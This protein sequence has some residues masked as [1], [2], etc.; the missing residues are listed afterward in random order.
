MKIIEGLENLGIFEDGTIFSFTSCKPLK[1]SIHSS[2]YEY[3]QFV[4]NGK[5]CHALVHRL[6]AKAF[7]PN[8]DNKPCINHIDGNKTNN[9]LENLEWCTYSENTEH[10]AKTLK[11]LTQYQKYNKKRE[12]PVQGIYPDGHK[13]KIFSSIKEASDAIGATKSQLICTLK[14]RKKTCRGA[15]WI[16]KD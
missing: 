16:Y 12:R 15:V 2:G 9:S 6:L 14:G 11:R 10:A 3:V 4:H 5:H 1:H 8:P 7:I 13:T